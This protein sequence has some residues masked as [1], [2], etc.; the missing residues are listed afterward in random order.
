MRQVVQ[1]MDTLPTRYVN[2]PYA[3]A[4]RNI[5]GD[6]RIVHVTHE[7]CLCITR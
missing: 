1:K 2:P 6:L 3:K 4:R 5:D 7:Q